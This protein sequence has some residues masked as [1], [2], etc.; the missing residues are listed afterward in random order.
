[1]ILSEDSDTDVE[2]RKQTPQMY[3]KYGLDISPFLNTLDIFDKSTS[4]L[5]LLSWL[6]L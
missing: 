1:M 2:I 5:V 6:H 4:I 3:K